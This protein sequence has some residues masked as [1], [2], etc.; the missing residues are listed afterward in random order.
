MGHITFKR[1]KLGSLRMKKPL[2]FHVENADMYRVHKQI[3]SISMKSKF[4]CMGIINKNN[5][6]KNIFMGVTVKKQGVE[7]LKYKLIPEV[8]Y[9]NKLN[10]VT[11]H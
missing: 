9:M 3:Y 7:I 2:L 1:V 10:K 11:K 6:F 5:I 4:Y 8:V